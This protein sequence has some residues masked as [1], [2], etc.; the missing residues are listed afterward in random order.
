MATLSNYP[1]IEPILPLMLDGQ[2]TEIMI[3]GHQ[4]LY[5]E[6]GG[7]MQQIPSPFGSEDELRTMIEVLLRP[8]GRAV[9]SAT[10]FTDFRLP[11]GSRGN[12]IIP[13]LALNGPVVTIRKFTRQLATAADLIRVGTL[14]RRMAA[15]LAAAVAARANILFSGAAGTGKTTTLNIFSHF[16]PPTERILTIEDTAELQL[17][18]PHVV[19]LECRKANLEGRGEVTMAQ[20]VRNAL[21]MRPTRIIVGEIRGEEALLRRLLG[22]GGKPG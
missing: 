1:G 21:R 14:S 20:L 2:I 15:L 6:R 8:T 10:P 5:V 17:Q 12:V 4:Q 7:V 16:I 22:K 11:D 18:Q 13:P 3:N 19:R 9:S